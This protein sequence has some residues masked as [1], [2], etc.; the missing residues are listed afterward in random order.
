M[1]LMPFATAATALG[2]YV[3][4]GALKQVPE[5]QASILPLA[6]EIDRWGASFADGRLRVCAV[7]LESGRRVVFGRAPAPQATV[8]E[9]VA[10]SS[11]IPGIF[12]PVRIGHRRYVDG[13][14][15]TSTNA[16]ASATR[17]G[18]RVLILAPTVAAQGADVQSAVTM[19]SRMLRTGGATVRVVT[20]DTEASVLMKDLLMP[21]D[22]GLVLAAGYRQGRELGD[23]R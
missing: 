17:F 20:P 2:A 10:A 8:G 12:R 21:D 13:G 4:S 19:E 18:D 23:T 11:A 6:M 15:W 5:G 22:G 16:D 9:A 3:R 7:D 14:A 1:T